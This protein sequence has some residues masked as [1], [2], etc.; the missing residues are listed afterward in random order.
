MKR[1]LRLLLLAMTVALAPFMV[2]TAS[3]EASYLHVSYAQ[4]TAKAHMWNTLC[5]SVGCRDYPWSTGWYQRI[6]SNE[7]RVEVKDYV[8]GS[9]YCW[10]VFDVRGADYAAY[11]STSGSAPYYSCRY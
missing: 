1:I 9:G 7:V 8:Y 11:I 10:R 2:T 5:A 6:N 3:A 4:S